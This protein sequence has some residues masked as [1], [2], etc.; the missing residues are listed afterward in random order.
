MVLEVA[1]VAELVDRLKPGAMEEGPLVVTIEPAV[2]DAAFV[3]RT[4]ARA[5][6][7]AFFVFVCEPGSDTKLRRSL[8]YAG[9][10][11]G[12]WA[13]VEARGDVLER[14]IESTVRNALQQ[15]R[16]RTTVGRVAGQLSNTRAAQKPAF[17]RL[18]AS[19]HYLANL[20]R[21]AHDAIVSLTVE[22]EVVSWNRAAEA[23]FDRS[24]QDALGAKFQSLFPNEAAI[25][26]VLKTALGK[27]EVRRDLMTSGEGETAVIADA[28]FA[29]IEDDN[30]GVLGV[31]VTLREV[32]VQ[33]RLERLAR[34]ADRRKDEF[35][36]MLAHELRNPLAPITNQAEFI[37]RLGAQD[38]RIAHASNVISRQAHHLKELLDELLDI[39]RVTRG[40]ISIERSIL[41]PSDFISPAVEQVRA[42]IDAKHQSL[43]IEYGDEQGLVSGDLHRLTQVVANL[44]HNATQYTPHG[45]AISVAVSTTPSSINVAVCDNGLGIDAQLLPHIFE[46]FTQEAR[47]LDR[48]SGGLGIGLAMV[49]SLVQLH[50]GRVQAM[51]AGLGQGSQF[52]VSLPRL[53]TPSPAQAGSAGSTA[54]HDGKSR[55]VLVVDDNA[56]AA[57]SLAVLLSEE[58]HDVSVALSGEQALRLVEQTE[59]DTFVLDIGMP[60]MDGYTLAATL[61]SRPGVRHATLIAHTG[62]GQPEDRLR[63]QQAGF[64]HHLTKPADPNLLL[65]LVARSAP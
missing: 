27:E 36:A 13:V 55:H 7:K 14:K 5:C 61:R 51:S 63:A 45:G 64:D 34:E 62:Y 2:P 23:L 3:G 8:M 53:W 21:T 39:S 48:A 50:D 47:T 9:P 31:L 26:K 46:L 1:S 44:L 17:Q 25:D 28:V 12:R 56:D 15:Y 38:P 10:P 11:G 40:L 33:R 4:I 42:S 52:I 57:E 20:M 59:F 54:I 30:A 65:D 22:G 18:V 37:G 60:G 19:D 41:L 6:P 16:F 58:G 43:S 29:A 35:L 32:T 24:E 49:R